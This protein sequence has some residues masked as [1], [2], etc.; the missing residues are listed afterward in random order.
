M[1]LQEA[2]TGSAA[3]LLAALLTL[4]PAANVMPAATN[5]QAGD[6]SADANESTSKGH[7][8]SSRP[9]A[10][11][12]EGTRSQSTPNEDL[13]GARFVDQVLAVAQDVDPELGR[14]LRQACD[15][16]PTDFARILRTAGGRLI[17]LARLREK[18][19]QL[20]SLKIAEMQ[21]DSQAMEIAREYQQAVEKG[22]KQRADLLEEQL[23]KTL[24]VHM[25]L[26]L[27]A[28][29][30]YLLRLEQHV[31]KL[32]TQLEQDA[33]DF[34][35]RVEHRLETLKDRAAQEKDSLAAD[36]G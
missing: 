12:A 16:H 8:D 34:E 9:D 23:R 31:R 25:A 3:I 36:G 22:Q 17:A 33:E 29:G 27:K 26:S 2:L 10:E 20:Y 1:S 7:I 30:D 18:D 24:Q 32:R 15:R 21:W 11:R 4:A 14:K 6:T 5:D 13:M 19:P 28:R 35:K